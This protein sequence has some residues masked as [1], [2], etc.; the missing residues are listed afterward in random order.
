MAANSMRLNMQVNVNGRSAT[1]AFTKPLV[2][3]GDRRRHRKQVTELVTESIESLLTVLGG[4]FDQES[5][6]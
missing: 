3:S 6:S 5:D 4:Q 1:V 2:L